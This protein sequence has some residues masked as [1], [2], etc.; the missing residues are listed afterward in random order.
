MT[1][2]IGINGFGRIGRQAFRAS[3]SNPDVR[4]VA[5][6]DPFL[7]AEA[8]AHAIRYDSSAG[9]FKGTVE[10]KGKNLLVVDGSRIAFSAV[11]D[12]TTI[13]WAEHAVAY[14]LECSGV[15]T[16]AERAAAH[17]A[18]GAQRVI[19]AT[20]S[21]DA[22]PIIL[23]ANE[24]TF[25]GT[26]QV[27]SAG[28]CTA[29]ALAPVLKALNS[30][31]GVKSCT[32]TAIHSA[33]GAKV[34]DST[35]SK[36]LRGSR[37]ALGTIAPIGTGA[38]RTVTRVIPRLQGRVSGTS[39]R[40]PT[41]CVSLLD[42]NVTLE[43]PITKTGV[44]AALS[45]VE[46]TVTSAGEVESAQPTSPSRTSPASP[47][48][49]GKRRIPILSVVTDSVISADFVGD[50]HA[51]IVDVTASF[52][53]PS[54]ATPANAPVNPA[55]GALGDDAPTTDFKLMVWFDNERGYAQ[56]LIDLVSFT[57][58]VWA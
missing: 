41:S 10:V 57:G 7:D 16:T 26:S 56:R 12:P 23:G 36:D 33:N 54:S 34:T 18:G 51:G 44:I 6:N 39:I 37:A 31:T 47:S 2:N 32:F 22:P 20:T 19:I 9:R 11:T 45:T 52:A 3:L 17:L 27:I 49:A 53:I 35:N 30:L 29:V 43:S 1:T 38:V 24:E 40:V 48:A 42:I 46:T 8:A 28:S 21:A 58:S 55:T 5:I 14:V 50:T 13:P 15:F 25:R 4:V